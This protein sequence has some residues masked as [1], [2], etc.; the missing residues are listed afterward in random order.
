PPGLAKKIS[1]REIFDDTMLLEMAQFAVNVVDS[2]DPDDT[3]T[4]FE[5]DRDLGNGWNLDDDPL[6][7]DNPSNDQRDFVY[8][9]ETQKLTLSESLFVYV[10]KTSGNDN[11]GATEF[12][13]SDDRSFAYIELQNMSDQTINFSNRVYQI[14]LQVYEK[15]ASG[16][17]T[18]R[19]VRYLTPI[20][21]TVGPGERFTIG[22][23]GD[24]HNQNAG[25]PRPS[26]FRVDPAYDPNAMLPPNYQTVIP[27]AG[28][29]NLDLIT[30][31]GFQLNDASW[32][33]VTATLGALFPPAEAKKVDGD[34]SKAADAGRRFIRVNLRRRME[35]GVVGPAPDANH[36]VTD[37]NH[38][39]TIDT[40]EIDPG[41]TNGGYGLFELANDSVPAATVVTKLQQLLSVEREQPLDRSNEG[42]FS[43]AAIVSNSLGSGNSNTPGTGFQLYQPLFNRDFLSVVELLSVPLYGPHETTSKLATGSQGKLVGDNTAAAKFLLPQ[44]PSNRN[45]FA[46]PDGISSG[47]TIE[48]KLDNRW[49]RLLELVTVDHGLDALY[50]DSLLYRRRIWGGLCL[51]TIDDES[52]LAGLIEDD[53]VQGFRDLSNPLA[54][55]FSQTTRNW[56][57]QFLVARDGEDPR[58]A[59]AALGLP[60]PGLPGV[61]RPFVPFS[62]I[63]AAGA[64]PNVVNQSIDQTLLRSHRAPESTEADFSPVGSAHFGLFEAR[65]ST[66]Y[67]ATGDTANQNLVDYHTRQRILAKIANNTTTRNNLFVVWIRF[68]FFEAHTANDGGTPVVQIG[69]KIDDVHGATEFLVVDRTRLEEGLDANGKLNFAPFIIYRQRVQ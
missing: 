58:T 4:I 38:W 47:G 50:R 22:T 46:P 51:N 17:E 16:A 49:F 9:V 57:R 2:L 69:S 25:T 5:Y 60:L 34:K 32:G 12:D 48:P 18:E 63:H 55:R 53:M 64:D 15:D 6:T 68:D 37:S 31:G 39:I 28:S 10:K 56:Y 43:P 1:A 66:D 62:Q 30:G 35:A 21:G 29:L 24:D 41:S 44:H 27:A 19:W 20:T 65:D 52:A 67:D 40:M 13:E 54:N 8:G 11:H 36:N 42:P 3:T 7:D 23:A 45:T 26:Y 61:G 14:Q 59:A 33:N